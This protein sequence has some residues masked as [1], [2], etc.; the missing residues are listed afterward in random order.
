MLFCKFNYFITV[1]NSA[2]VSDD[3]LAVLT[4]TDFLQ[5]DELY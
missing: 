3:E 2:F 5:T 1:H 4:N